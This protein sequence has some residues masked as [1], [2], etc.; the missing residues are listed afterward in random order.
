MLQAMNTGHDGS[1]TT[2]HS[3][4]PRD[5]LARME[6]MAMMGSVSLPERAIQGANCVRRPSDCA[7]CPNE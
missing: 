3:N 5:A 6:T 2:I 1:L 4:T 7:D